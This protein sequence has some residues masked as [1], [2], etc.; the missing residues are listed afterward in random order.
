MKLIKWLFVP[1]LTMIFLGALYVMI[2]VTEAH[3]QTMTIKQDYMAGQWRIKKQDPRPLK[4]KSTD[5]SDW[6]KNA[7]IKIQ[8]PD[9]FQHSGIDLQT[10]GAGLTTISQAIAKKLYFEDFKPGIAKFKQTIIA[11]FIIDKELKKEQQLDLFLNATYMG[12]HLGQSIYGFA[13]AST[14]YLQKPFAQLSEDEYLSLLAMLVAPNTFHT[15]QHPDANQQ[16][17]E[18]I[19]RVLDGSYQVKSLDD[20]YY[21]R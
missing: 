2:V 19:K 13:D 12:E 8:D 17:V 18:R 16:R 11:V 10:P 14:A 1:F 20:I 9:F 4:L 7:L 15:L 21:D 3:L 6:Q 5:L